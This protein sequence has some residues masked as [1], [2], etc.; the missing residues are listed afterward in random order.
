MI[1]VLLL[2]LILSSSA[3]AQ[4]VIVGN[5][6]Q[7]QIGGGAQVIVAPG[8]V[9]VQAGGTL[10]L[11]GASASSRGV[12]TS[13]VMTGILVTVQLG[14][15]LDYK[16]GRLES[17]LRV[18]VASG[19]KINR[20]QDTVFTD[21]G[22]L[23]PGATAWIDLSAL[24]AGDRA[25]LPFS[26][27][28]VTFQD[29]QITPTR[30]SIKS[31]AGTPL[32]RV[33]GN[34]TAHGNRWGNTFDQD[35][36]NVV[37]W[38]TGQV[39]RSG[40]AGT[41][42]T[43]EDA[44]RD[45]ATVAASTITVNLG[46]MA[47]IDDI[48]DFALVPGAGA[49]ASGP[50][51]LSA[52]LAP[53]TG[54]AVCDS[55]ADTT[56]RGKI[57]NCVIARG[58]SEE[59]TAEN[60]TFF[61][62]GAAVVTLN[63][64]AGSNLLIE[65]GFSG[66]GN[67]TFTTSLTTA[68]ST[69]FSSATSYNFHLVSPGGNAAVDEGSAQSVSTDI[70]GDSRG[71]Y[72]KVGGTGTWDIGADEL[73]DTLAPTITNVTST[74]ANGSY[75]A[76]A[77]INVTVNFSEPVTLAGGNLQVTLNT[78]TV[79]SIPPFGPASSAS[80]SYTVTAGQNNADL[81]ATSPLTLSAGTLRDAV[82]LNAILSIPANQNLGNL[83]DIVIDTTAPSITSLTSTTLNGTYPIGAS[84][85]ITVNFSEPVILAGGNLQVTLSTGTVVSIAPFGPSSSAIG[86]Y[87]VLAGQT[88][89]DLNATTPLTLQAGATLRDVATNTSGLA[90]PA[91]QNLAD[92]KAIVIEAIAPT[93]SNVSSTNANGSYGTGLSVNV[94]V[95]F[96]EAVTL[97][98]GNLVVAL[99]T[100]ASVVIPPFASSSTANGT[101]V[102]SAGEN[103]PDLNATSP[104]TLSA[105]TL[106]DA[107][108]NNA[109]LTIPGTQNLAD[110][111]D[112]LIDTN[113]PTVMTV[114]ST[115]PN[116]TYGT[117]ASINVTVNFFEPVTL[118]GGNLLVTLDTGAV[119]AV[120]PFGP[121]S[122]VSGTYV[123]ASGQSSLDLNAANPLTLS[124]G[125]TLRDPAGNNAV[126]SIPANGNIADLKAII[127]NTPPSTAPLPP[128]NVRTISYGNAI[129]VEWD[130]SASLPANVK[131]YNVFRRPHTTLTWPGTPLNATVVT[132]TI[133]RDSTATDP[134]V[135]YFYR[136][137]T[138]GF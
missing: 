79:V 28:R 87:T 99:S 93:I 62:P 1:R 40:P 111:K 63:N 41:F 64:M 30:L 109:V 83:K 36:S 14:G 26:F 94:R 18:V 37:L 131:G 81:T 70:D 77:V 56:R 92:L 5:G 82:S 4:S 58:I 20:I 7:E 66:T 55:D 27:N 44:L 96:S 69:F 11:A 102:V 48:A 117:G 75:K 90:V 106:R 17:I 76:G 3:F 101:Y 53:M 98:G 50:V 125:A 118:V 123:V 57:V 46:S 21:L 138:V 110:L 34:P 25:N 19:A 129:D 29:P 84:I 91:G 12:L 73:L 119:V 135:T 97:T 78:G 103:S 113:A 22:G 72:G 74:T 122:T 33:L 9:D 108:G 124:I 54:K 15:T 52:C 105:G 132:S 38:N 51:V 43:V 59:S 31:A 45:A 68:A 32:L 88:S 104:L 89:P 13:G 127:I 16:F 49:S 61:D 134:A 121:A 126:L 47:F 112:I 120:A 60:C 130:P 95:T 128:T 6:S 107:A 116:G 137:T 80:G 2:S 71:A 133:Y 86:T 10:T 114:T 100:G 35:T 65:S 39:A 23:N 8:N 42:D 115:T 24:V 67:A 85:N 136:V